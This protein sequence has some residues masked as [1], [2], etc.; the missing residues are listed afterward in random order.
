MLLV[1]A[2]GLYRLGSKS[3]WLDEAFALAVARH[4][5]GSR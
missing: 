5:Q 3:L 2:L 1:G 4:E